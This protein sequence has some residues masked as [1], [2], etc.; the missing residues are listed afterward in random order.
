MTVRV[1]RLTNV[2]IH[3]PP[4]R[5]IDVLVP[6]CTMH[7][8]RANHGLL[9]GTFGIRASVIRHR[10][11]RLWPRIALHIRF[12]FLLSCRTPGMKRVGGAPR[13]THVAFDAVESPL[14]PNGGAMAP[15]GCNSK[16]G[17][18]RIGRRVPINEALPRGAE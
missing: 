8:R 13:G 9:A 12:A 7:G 3:T 15:P 6:F 5:D 14:S 18:R 11:H 4:K 10:D 1:S 2:F 17:S 16:T